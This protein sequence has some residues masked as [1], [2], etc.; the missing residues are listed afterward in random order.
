MAADKIIRSGIARRCFT[1]IVKI[2]IFICTS[3]SYAVLYAI[4]Y[5]RVMAS[6]IFT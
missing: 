4:L 3:K 5:F 2:T 1:T 6:E